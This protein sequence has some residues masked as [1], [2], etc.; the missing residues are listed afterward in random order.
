MAE[1]DH[2]ILDVTDPAASLAFYTSILG[3]TDDGRD[4]PFT[5]VRVSPTCTLLLA[6]RATHGGQH[7]AFAMSRAELDA[8]WQRIRAAAIPFGDAFNTIGSG[9]GPGNELGARGP[10]DTI[11]VFDPDRHLI[12]IRC[13][14][15]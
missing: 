7:L 13:Y 9:R 12:E 15:S 11:Y 2:L 5:V 4:G 8:T 10:G 6:R 14:E 3:F 1:L